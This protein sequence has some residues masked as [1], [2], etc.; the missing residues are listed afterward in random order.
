MT[1]RDGGLRW[2]A[3]TITSRMLQHLRISCR[4]ARASLMQSIVSELD[5][6]TPPWTLDLPDGNSCDSLPSLM[7]RK[8]SSNGWYTF[9]LLLDGMYC[10]YRNTDGDRRNGERD[11]NGI[12]LFSYRSYLRALFHA[13][14]HYAE[15]TIRIVSNEVFSYSL[16]D[17]CSI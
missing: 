8:I 2:G 3:R 6:S 17:E 11:L 9:H 14:R 7:F 12:P 4:T 5:I 1:V 16:C 15:E 10:L 13:T